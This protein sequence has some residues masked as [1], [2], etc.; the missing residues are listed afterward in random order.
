MFFHGRHS[1]LKDNFFW[2]NRI[3]FK[4]NKEKTISD[5]KNSVCA[6]IPA[7]NEEKTITRTLKSLA[8]QKIK[9][10]KII[11]VDD[12]STDNTSTLV[13]KF[14]QTYK[15]IQLVKGKKLPHDWVGKT[16]ALKQGVDFANK[17]IF[18]YYLFIDSDII[19][20]KEIIKKVINFMET[21]NYIMVS[22]MARLNCQSFWEKVLIPPFIFFFQKIYPF[23]LVNNKNSKVSAAAGGFIFSKS[24]IFKR[25]NLYEK[26]KNNIIDDCNLAKLIKKKGPIWLGLT[27]D[28]ISK[29]SY[30]EVKSIW[31]MVS[32]SAF[33][34]LKNSLTIVS[35]SVLGLFLIYVLPIATVLS[36]I[37]KI[38]PH[39]SN[40]FLLMPNLISILIMFII[41]V[42]TLRFYKV[43]IF[44][45]FAFPISSI[46]YIFMTLTSVINHYLF[47]GNDWKGRKY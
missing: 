21:N 24:F 5:L 11:V 10:L 35:F 12:N 15:N 17:K 7:R 36:L 43:N 40:Y 47:L 18:K 2:S 42:P 39:T 1:I 46:L 4:Q 27:D 19:L 41:I 25:I 37:L 34:Q 9:N 31:K 23:N 26:I 8:K 22:L 32:R 30:K 6:I 28:V 29:R 16:W 45:F 13:K 44:Y 20:K 33:E 3:I 38:T 14:K